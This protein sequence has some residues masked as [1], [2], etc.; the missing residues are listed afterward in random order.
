MADRTPYI[1]K[2][3]AV[4]GF[5]QSRNGPWIA[6]THTR[7]TLPHRH[8]ST[9]TQKRGLIRPGQACFQNNAKKK[10]PTLP[11]YPTRPQTFPFHNPNRA[12]WIVARLHGRLRHDAG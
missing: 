10:R 11:L 7:L 5:F 8:H 6:Q 4:T 1:S 2:I 12:P 3:N 9:L